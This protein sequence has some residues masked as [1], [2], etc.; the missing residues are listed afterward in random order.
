MRSTLTIIVALGLAGTVLLPARAQDIPTGRVD[1]LGDYSL[2]LEEAAL[3]RRPVLLTFYTKWC[4]WC[5]KLEGSTFQSPEFVNLSRHMIPVRVDGDKE[6]ALRGLFRITGYP[7]TVLVSRQGRELTRISGYQPAEPFV[8]Q[9]IGGMD[10]RE[11]LGPATTRVEEQ[12]EDP[13]AW[14]ALG[15][16]FLALQRYDAARE[17]FRTVIALSKGDATDLVDDSRLDI[18]L[19]YLFSFS[20]SEAIPLLEDFLQVHPESD[21]RD[22]ALFFYGVALVHSGQTDKGLEKI[23]E[24][25]AITS[26]DYIKFE[27]RR[28]RAVTQQRQGQG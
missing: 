23:D 19:S 6:G 5:R 26:L 9:L 16:V 20:P 2:A 10:R 11:P 7:T 27:A 17:A 15:D 21:R 1:W 24:A 13:A 28:L 12:P 14:Y 22:Q 4:G 8:N 18:A 3:T 25:V